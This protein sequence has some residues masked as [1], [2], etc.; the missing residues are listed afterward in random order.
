MH[1]PEHLIAEIS[2]QAIPLDRSGAAMDRLVAMAAD[3]SY[4]LIGEATHGTHEFYAIRAE[5]T[6][7][8]IVEH[9][10]AAVAAEADWP[11]SYRVNRYVRGEPSITSADSALAAFE[12]FPRWMWRNTVVRDFVEWLRTHN[13]AIDTPAE[14]IGFYGL[15]LY[16]LEASIE[17]VVAYLDKVD[18]A[19]AT[20]ARA[21]YGCFDHHFARNPQQYGYATMLGLTPGCEREV[22]DQLA[23]LRRKRFDYLT[24]DGFAAGEDFYCAEQNAAVVRNAE[25]Y[26]RTMFEGRVSS[27]N[28]RDRHMADTLFGLADHLHI[29]RGTTPKIVVWAHN[30]HVGD[31]RATEM[32]QRGEW[33]IGSLVREAHGRNACLIGFTTHHGT[34]RAASAWDG[35]GEV[36]TVR[37][38][39]SG[40]YEG[41]FHAVGIPQ[42]LL[43]LRDNPVMHRHL[44]LSRLQRAIGVLY[45]PETERQSHYVFAQLPD[46][47]DAVIH[48]DVT[49]ALEALPPIPQQ[50]QMGVLET[51]PT[52]V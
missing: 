37:P 48:V 28:L 41:L 19:A 29:Q 33:N 4:V 22:L 52:G 30:S 17:A 24:R 32:G 18:P 44:E 40:S 34:V 31:A 20:L 5:L 15:D 14:R 51:Y 47:F 35:P 25:H 39:M 11:D 9:G 6:K 3:A 2:G 36:K 16:S 8:L 12:R 50:P 26:Y 27:W 10:F 49:R 13:E 23:V 38:G 1:A 46:Q 42:F 45:L 21:H 7:R 43:V